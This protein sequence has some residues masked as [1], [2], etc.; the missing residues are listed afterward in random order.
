MGQ[1]LTYASNQS[2]IPPVQAFRPYF[3][4]RRIHLP[5]LGLRQLH[6]DGMWTL[7]PSD[8]ISTE[9]IWGIKGTWNLYPFSL[10]DE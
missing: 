6:R 7:L 10:L 3:L 8:L 1:V 5:H 4:R 2:Y 9:G